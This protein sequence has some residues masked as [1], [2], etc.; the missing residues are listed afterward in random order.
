M[1]TSSAL[2]APAPLP[3]NP[4]S[5]DVPFDWRG[6]L[7]RLLVCNPFFLGSAALLLLAVNR[8]SLDP[9]FL[10]SETQKLL[11]NFGALQ[12]Y[13]VLLVGTA[14]VLARRR[15]WYDSALL[16]VLEHG[17]LLVPFILISQ[18]ALI[19]SGLAAALVLAGAAL[20][21]VRAGALRRW[22]GRFN[23]PLRALALGAVILAANVA[24]P[25][26][27]RSVVNAT[28]VLD[29]P[30][31]NR[32]V[33]LAVL[34]LLAAGANLLPRP[35]R[36]G[37]VSPERSW[38]P[39]F[40]Y[41]LW[42]AGSAVHAWSVAYLGKGSAVT[43]A[44]LAPLATV[45]AWTFRNRLRDVW[46]EPSLP[47]GQW[48]LAAVAATPLLAWD[49][50]PVL[51]ALSAV[52]FAG[53]LLL[54]LRRRDCLGRLAG[55]LAGLSLPLVLVG[56]PAECITL[57]RP[58]WQRSEALPV[59]LG[60]YAVAVSWLSRRPWAGLAGG[61]AFGWAA[62]QANSHVD[63]FLALQLSLV[64]VLCHGL[65]WN[66]ELP[67]RWLRATVAGAWVLSA[68]LPRLANEF[69]STPVLS[70]SLLVLAVWGMIWWIAHR[71]PSR[72]VPAAAAAVMLSQ[73]ISSGVE[74]GSGGL[75]VLALSFALYG[76]GTSVALLRQKTGSDSSPSPS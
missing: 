19:G 37:G 27:F 51:L 61:F 75:L 6:W 32:F 40:I 69:G 56:L 10:G 22:Y 28:T 29:W 76:V 58:G 46:A 11:F 18:A 54:R 4:R 71:C 5:A 16:V 2:P 72:V 70:E 15:I 33:W 20:A 7:R 3:L 59:A 42:L 41:G 31:P 74:H 23:L 38:L 67:T 43:L 8:L 34:P 65:R 26:W 49:E 64:V 55:Q 63:L 12:F 68:F 52:N 21:A 50:Q 36:H 48:S 45:A 47:A 25:L 53:L 57:G 35:V 66:H 1:D 62:V 17:L 60:L 73:P 39:L 14:I 9:D 24:L 13:S 44:M 30:G